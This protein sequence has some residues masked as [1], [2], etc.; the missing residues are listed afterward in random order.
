M[1]KSATEEAGRMRLRRDDVID[2]A[3]ALLDEVGL[4]ALT[5]RRLADRLGVRVGALYW[6]VKDKNELLTTLADRIV[7]QAH[8]APPAAGDDW[9]DQ[10]ATTAHRLR[11]ALLAHRDGARIVAGYAPVSP[12]SLDA[13]ERGLRVA[14]E[15]GVPLAVAALAGDTV[16]SYVTGY[17]LQEQSPEPESPP[18]LAGRPLLAEWV[19]ARPDHDTA[20]ATGLATILTGIRATATAA[21]RPADPATGDRPARPAASSGPAGPAAASSGPAGP[22]AAG[23]QA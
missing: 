6:H 2:A 16:M 8:R 13:A 4:D 21:G 12:G 19:R 7:A 9:A 14:R 17:V 3:L 15:A 11:A 20:F 18:T 1:F 10:L 23:D 5:T 22:A